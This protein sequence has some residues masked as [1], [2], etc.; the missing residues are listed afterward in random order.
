LRIGNFEILT[1]V[2]CRRGDLSPAVF[3]LSH[4]SV[5]EEQKRI[6]SIHSKH[7]G[8]ARHARVPPTR[9]GTTRSESPCGEPCSRLVLANHTDSLC[10]HTLAGLVPLV[11]STVALLA[12]VRDSAVQFAKDEVQSRAISACSRAKPG[13]VL[14]V[15]ATGKRSEG[16]HVGLVCAFVRQGTMHNDMATAALQQASCMNFVF[17]LTCDL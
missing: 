15:L 11:M 16:A 7:G 12:R 6:F 10:P 17:C 8:R 4:A 2:E 1:Y 13:Q 5:L 14:G 9:H 3:E